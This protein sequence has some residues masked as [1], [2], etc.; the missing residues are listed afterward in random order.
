VGVTGPDACLA[1]YRNPIVA[2]REVQPRHRA[3]QNI[4]DEYLR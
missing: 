2:D 4:A 1:D 3:A